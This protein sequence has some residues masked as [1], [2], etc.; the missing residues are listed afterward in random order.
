MQETLNIDFIDYMETD[1]VGDVDTLD[2]DYFSIE[3][4]AT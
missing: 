1:L 2:L 3:T 4:E